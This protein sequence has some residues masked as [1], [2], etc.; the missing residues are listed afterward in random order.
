MKKTLSTNLKTR[1]EFVRD[2]ALLTAGLTIGL[3]SFAQA[4]ED[5]AEM[6]KTRSYNPQMEYRRLGK[7]GLWVSA[8]CMGG[9][10][11]R[12]DKTIGSQ[13]TFGDC[14]NLDAGNPTEL[15]AFHKNRRDV[16]SRCLEQGI[17]CIDFAGAAEPYAY[18]KAI[19]GRREKIYISWS[20]GG[21]EMR[22]EQH[23]KADVL[24]GILETGLRETGLEYADLWRVMA[25]ER[26]SLHTEEEIEEMISAL[27]TAKK[28]GLCRFT[29]IS[30][31]DRPWAKKLIE[32]Y[33]DDIQVL[34]TPYTAN[35]KI[36]PK[37]SLFEAVQKHDVG[38]LGIKPFASNS[39]FKGDGSLD[40]PNAEEDDKRA[41]LA[42]R[43]IL[44]NPAIT[45]PIP[46]LINP[47]QVDNVV[48]AVKERRELDKT[49]KAELEH[50]SKEM[51]ANLPHD[52]QWLKEWEYV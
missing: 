26:G 46:G 27:Q 41:R 1:R 24:V 20:M 35:S 34:V 3:K 21:Q 18:G 7:T 6:V 42:I 43:Y 8:V 5:K 19:Q 30:T 11:K 51:W 10:W 29:G 2:S 9:H 50:A 47:H 31:H 52:Y 49:E 28:K 22:H 32:T 13:A 36:L 12:I 44:N 38:I 15:E 39:I 23:R 33:P 4:A 45:A 25:H 17:N 40:S 37:D 48:Q 14:E 16:V